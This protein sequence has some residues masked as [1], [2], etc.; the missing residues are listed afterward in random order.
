MQKLGSP[1]IQLDA[2]YQRGIGRAVHR[3]QAGHDC[4][5]DIRPEENV[6]RAHSFTNDETTWSPIAPLYAGHYW[7]LVS[8]RDRNTSE[9]RYSA[10]SD[11]TIELSFELDELPVHKSLSH[12]WLRISLRWKGNMHAV[13]FKL[14]LLRHGQIIWARRGLRRNHIGSPGSVSFT[15]HRPHG[16]KQGS[17]LTVREG[18]SA[19]GTTAGAGGF[20][21]VRAP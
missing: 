13:R 17:V 20:F 9:L 8:S 11:F 12:H 2:A 15:W 18:I 16:V 7:W 5:R 4:G 1:G 21:R 6:V 14:S 19:P 3:R 10:P